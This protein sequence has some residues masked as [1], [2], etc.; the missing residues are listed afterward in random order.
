MNNPEK[1]TAAT[2]KTT[3]TAPA[4]KRA[5]PANWLTVLGRCRRGGLGEL[6]FVAEAVGPSRDCVVWAELSLLDMLPSCVITSDNQAMTTWM[7]HV[8]RATAKGT[9]SVV[10]GAKVIDTAGSPLPEIVPGL[11]EIEVAVPARDLPCGRCRASAKTHQQ[12]KGIA[13]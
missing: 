6:A 7:L 9:K 10:M 12:E 2:T 13:R 5:Q 4:T 1:K 8:D 3:N 11:V